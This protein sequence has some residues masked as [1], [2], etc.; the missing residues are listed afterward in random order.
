VARPKRTDQIVPRSELPDWND[1]VVHL[2]SVVTARRELPGAADLESMAEIFSA[3]ADPTRL[4]IVAALASSEL[5]VADLAATVGLSQS[6]ASHQLRV[7]RERGLVRSRKDGRRA[8]Y[9]LDD[10][11]VNAL[12]RQAHEHAHHLGEAGN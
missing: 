4:R 10:E 11:H 7:L 5:C 12:Y 3:L 9:A 2:E 8:Y 6:A 1:K